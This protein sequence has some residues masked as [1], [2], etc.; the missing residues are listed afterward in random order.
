MA[1]LAGVDLGLSG[2]VHE[3]AHS[4]SSI[5]KFTFECVD[6][7]RIDCLLVH[8]VPSFYN[9]VRKKCLILSTV[10]RECSFLAHPACS[11][12]QQYFIISNIHINVVNV[13]LWP[14]YAL[15]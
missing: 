13:I 3:E 8:L 14:S 7:V 1:S 15:M 11:L 12:S 10:L 2:L 9:S 6:V 4:T 5:S